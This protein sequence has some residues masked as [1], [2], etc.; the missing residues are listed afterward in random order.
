MSGVP[1]SKNE[2]LDQFNK[3][4]AHIETA[5]EMHDFDR[6]RRIDMAR[7][8]MLHEF[9]SKVMPDGDKVF[10]DT[11]EMR[12]RQCAGD[13]P[14]HVG[15]GR[16][17]RKAGRKMRQLNGYRASAPVAL[18][19]DG[20]QTPASVGATAAFTCRA[21]DHQLL[22]LFDQ[23]CA[24]KLSASAAWFTMVAFFQCRLNQHLHVSQVAAQ[25]ILSK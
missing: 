25:I 18:C 13:H 14:Y 2:V 22:H 7:R 16:I 3:L 11:L 19:A 9:T 1:V 5:L 12:R 20:W 4:N 8:Q 15:N 6:A 23:G 21:V 10:F 17:R 24:A